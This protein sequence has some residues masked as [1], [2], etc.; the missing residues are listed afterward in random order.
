MSAS[1]DKKDV[2]GGSLGALNGDGGVLYTYQATHWGR[3]QD[4]TTKKQPAMKSPARRLLEDKTETNMRLL[5][6]Q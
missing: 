2:V 6:A 5:Q 3:T 1:A 4:I